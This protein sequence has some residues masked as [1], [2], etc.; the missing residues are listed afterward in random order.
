MV[1]NIKFKWGKVMAEEKKKSTSKAASGKE[2]KSTAAK[3]KKT[4][5]KKETETT[6]PETN[7][8]IDAKDNAVNLEIKK[9][10]TSNLK[11][12]A[13]KS[14]KTKKNQIITAKNSIF[15]LS[16][17]NCALSVAYF[18]TFIIT[19]IVVLA[20]GG[21]VNGWYVALQTASII[22]FGIL[23]ALNYA[24][25]KTSFDYKKSN[26]YFVG[27]LIIGL[28]VGVISPIGYGSYFTLLAVV[29]LLIVSAVKLWVAQLIK[30]E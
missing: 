20:T 8:T 6:V 16:I 18:L 21:F 2:E 13:A 19:S 22:F 17:V 1:V 24:S 9:E 15:M 5:A 4:S 27:E 26:K 25:V 23:A 28:V 12:D 11:S 7:S 29:P 10:E 3:V 30:P 14:K